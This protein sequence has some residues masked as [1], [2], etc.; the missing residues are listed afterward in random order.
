MSNVAPTY[1]AADKHLVVAALPGI[2]EGDLEALA[3]PQLRG[4]WG[5]QVEG[6]EHLATYRI[7]H[8]QPT[9]RPP[10]APKRTVVRADGRFVCGDHRDTA[11]IQ[12]A[13]FSVGAVLRRFSIQ[14][15][16]SAYLAPP[17]KPNSGE[18]RL[19]GVLSVRS[20][21]ASCGPGWSRP[22]S[23]SKFE[24]TRLNRR[25]RGEKRETPLVVLRRTWVRNGPAGLR[26]SIRSARRRSPA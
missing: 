25:V 1:V 12:G 3:R 21:A 13:L 22:R 26:S 10:F 15:R 4:W 14:A 7:A 8:G 11:S 20:R 5:A 23:W 17:R 19:W 9:Q 2:I 6:W 24:S 16:P 18:R